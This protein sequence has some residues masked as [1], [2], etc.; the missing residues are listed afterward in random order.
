MKDFTYHRFIQTLR[1]QLAERK[2]IYTFAAIGLLV[3][4]LPTMVFPL[5]GGSYSEDIWTNDYA[6]TAST[7]L[8][9][10]YTWYYI[11]CGA[12]IV[13]NLGTKRK[14]IST[15]MLPASR[16]EKFAARY[17][18]LI[19]IVPLAFTLGAAAGDLLQMAVS[20]VAA[21]DCF[22][23]MAI[24]AEYVCTS[25]PRLSLDFGSWL[26]GVEVLFVLPHS[27]FL[28]TG[29]FFRRH[30]WILSNVLVFVAILVLACGIASLAH[31]FAEGLT[32]SGCYRV[33]II[34]DTWALAL[35]ML[36]VLAVVAF[37]YC[38]A[39]RI[40]SRMQAVSNRLRNF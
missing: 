28:L 12:L 23:A 32:E 30:A 37:N 9:I 39:F 21:G 13:D 22:S 14:R 6:E 29:T 1:W 18:H 36:A 5:I 16:L 31:Y 24:A 11:T 33:G 15:F 25:T 8:M 35:Y 40:Y 27:I 19:L 26:L 10:C 38:A 34:T 3:T 4:I 2:S 20:K 7:W 17:L